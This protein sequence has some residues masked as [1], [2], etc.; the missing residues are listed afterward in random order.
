[1]LLNLTNICI[2]IGILLVFRIAALHVI[3]YALPVPGSHLWFLTQ[4][5]KR[6]CLEQSKRS[7]WRQNYRHSRWNCVAII[8]TSWD[9][10]YFIST[11]GS[12][13]L[14]IIFH[15][16]W[17]RPAML[18]DAKHMRMPLKFH[19]YSIC[20]VRFQVFLVLRPPFCCPVEIASN[21]AQGDVA[22]SSGDFG[23]LK[24]KRSNVEFAS[25]DDLR[26]LIQW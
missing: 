16:P 18:F 6:Q 23:I 10:R 5:D 21:Y 2:A 9:I 7:A 24:N 8:C 4:P 19:T 12:R 1:M 20:N 14:S 22:I 13:S 17:R 26:H 25:K 3:W 11:S 15:P